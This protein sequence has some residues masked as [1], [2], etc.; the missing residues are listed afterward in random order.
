[1]A[2]MTTVLVFV[3][4]ERD[5]R[6]A[7]ADSAKAAD[8]AKADTHSTEQDVHNGAL[9]KMATVVLDGTKGVDALVEDVLRAVSERRTL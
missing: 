3:D 8:L 5:V 9:R 1:M 6:Q 7:R 4:V 2:P